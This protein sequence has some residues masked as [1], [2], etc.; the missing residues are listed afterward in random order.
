M[1]KTQEDFFWKIYTSH[2]ICKGTK[3]LLKGC[4]WEGVWDRTETSIFCPH[5]YDRQR[6]VFL[7]PQGCS[8]GGPG[9]TLLGA[10]FLYCIL[11]ASSLDPNSIRAPEGP[12]S[13]VW[14]SLPH[15]V[16]LPLQ[17]YWNSN[18][19]LDFRLDCAI[20]N[21]MFNRHQAEITVMQFRGHSLPVHQSMSVPW[22]L[23]CPISS[24][25]LRPR[26]FLS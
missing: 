12:F 19:P 2:F 17:L 16:P 13:R 8:N 21:R 5:C 14:L 24:A 11:S 23:P 7:V 18:W 26:D 9:P 10:S 4:V 20:W 22:A 6:C 3:G 1:I 15:L 25:N